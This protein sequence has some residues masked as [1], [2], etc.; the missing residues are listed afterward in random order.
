MGDPVTD[1]VSFADMMADLN[2]HHEQHLRY[3]AELE[4]E[5]AR[6]T[7]APTRFGFWAGNVGAAPGPRASFDAVSSYAGTPEVYRMFHSGWVPSTFA[8]SKADYGPSCVVSFKMNPRDVLAGK[9]DAAFVSFLQSATVELW[10]SYLH[11]PENDIEAGSFTVEEYRAAWLHLLELAPK[12]A[13]L[14]PTLILMRY[15]LSIPTKRQVKWYVVP[16]IE[17]LCWDSYLTGNLTVDDVIF[18]PK[19]VSDSFGLD[20]AI[21]ETSTNQPA[22]MVSFIAQLKGAAREAD[23]KF[24]CWFETNKA[25]Q[26]VNEYDWRMSPVPGALDA[27]RA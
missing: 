4:A 1:P 27:W 21:G 15:T 20:F 25:G 10:W 2:A 13:D 8:G 11:E 6:L 14:H 5:V 16:G 9:G 3:I 18:K 23:A 19:A 7:P 26:G 17:V 24:V 22:K 12:R